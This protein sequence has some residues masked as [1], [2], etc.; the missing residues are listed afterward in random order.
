MGRI[1]RPVGIQPHACMPGAHTTAPSRCQRFLCAAF[2]SIFTAT[3][4][5]KTKPESLMLYQSARLP[6]AKPSHIEIW[7]P[8]PGDPW[9]LI[10]VGSLT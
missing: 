3:L 2:Q 9:S 6:G 5:P 8:P 10:Q 1:H 7:S 4:V